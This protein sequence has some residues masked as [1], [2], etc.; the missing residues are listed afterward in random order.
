MA[1]NMFQVSN[2][3]N[4]EAARVGFHAAFMQALEALGADPIEAL[5]MMVTST[6]SLEEWD[7]LGDLPGFEEW[8]GD[9][10]LGDLSAFKMQV[11]N[12][13]WANGLRIHQNN[14]KDD[15]LGLLQPRVAGLAQKA[16][17]HRSDLMVRMILNGFAGN[18]FPDAGNGLAYDGAFFFSDT[19]SS[20][21]GPPQSNKITGGALTI[22]NLE[23]A[24]QKL[25]N[26]TTYDGKDPLELG[27]T[28]LVVG[29]ALEFVA[30]K[31]MGAEVIANAAGTAADTNIHRNQYQVVVSRRIRGA[32]ASNWFLADLSQ[33]IKPVM[34]QLREEI[35]TSALIGNQGGNGDSEPRFKRGELWFGA[36]A[37]YNVAP[38]A[39]QTIVGSNA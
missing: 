38:F 10:K 1:G 22:A 28:H 26:M 5:Y 31:L 33:P 19:H 39:W 32:Q 37:R 34:F 15:K 2:Q 18:V 24:E 13:D 25:K 12:K 29:P 23:L 27:G 30:K 20:D 3:I 4:L 7:W 14:F 11:T 36:E 9:R 17:R 21:G 35:S 16:R 6:G 8:K